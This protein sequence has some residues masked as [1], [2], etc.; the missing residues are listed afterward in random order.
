MSTCR[1]EVVLNIFS[2]VHPDVSIYTAAVDEKL[3]NHAYILPGLG[4]AGD[5][6]LGQ[7]KMEVKSNKNFNLNA[8]IDSVWNVLI[9]P[10]NSNLCP[11]SRA[12][13]YH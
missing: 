9:N 13:R 12:D 6:I 11:G 2:K 7:N 3:N 1:S 5:R 10:K 8:D 4:D